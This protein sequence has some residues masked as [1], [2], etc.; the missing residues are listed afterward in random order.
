MIKSVEA[1]RSGLEN[2]KRQVYLTNEIENVASSSEK[3]QEQLTVLI[4]YCEEVLV[5]SYNNHSLYNIQ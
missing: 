5:S 3:I 4:E 2:K 1:M